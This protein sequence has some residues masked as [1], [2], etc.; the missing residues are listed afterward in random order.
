[1][2]SLLSHGPNIS[3]RSQH[4]VVPRQG[5]AHAFQPS[6]HPAALSSFTG[7][8]C[9]DVC[10]A[11]MKHRQIVATLKLVSSSPVD[12]VAACFERADDSTIKLVQF[13][14]DNGARLQ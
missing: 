5:Q 2:V 11:N 14:W 10:N 9:L 3:K 12:H 1:M 8:P 4:V 13:A 6:S 7:S